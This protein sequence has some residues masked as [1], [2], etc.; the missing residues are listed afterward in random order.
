MAVNPADPWASREF[1]VK[2]ARY[3]YLHCSWDAKHTLSQARSWPR[4]AVA[5][6]RKLASGGRQ[7]RGGCSGGLVL[8]WWLIS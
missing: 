6:W 3:S 7:L 2:W 4:P 5:A 1:F 8:L